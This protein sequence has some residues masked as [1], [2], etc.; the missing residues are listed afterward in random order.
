MK[1]AGQ[2]LH[3]T[4]KYVEMEI[5]NPYYG[6]YKEYG[7]VKGEWGISLSLPLIRYAHNNKKKIRVKWKNDT[8]QTTPKRIQNFYNKSKIKPN[9]YSKGIRLIVVPQSVYGRLH[10]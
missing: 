3:S 8:Y 10:D 4:D 6:A 9:H 7:W 2:H 1:I 5:R